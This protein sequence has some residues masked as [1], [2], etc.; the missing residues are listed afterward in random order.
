MQNIA[1]RSGASHYQAKADTLEGVQNEQEKMI[2]RM[3][4]LIEADERKCLLAEGWGGVK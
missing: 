2:R 3:G 1:F 4:K